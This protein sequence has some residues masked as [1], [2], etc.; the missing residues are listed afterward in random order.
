MLPF[1]AS[2][3]AKLYSRLRQLILNYSTSNPAG[4]GR[5]KLLQ[6]GFSRTCLAKALATPELLRPPSGPFHPLSTYV[7]AVT[8]TFQGT[9]IPDSQARVQSLLGRV[10]DFCASA[11]GLVSTSQLSSLD[12]L[13]AVSGV[14]V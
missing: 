13:S 14:T 4:G 8:W 6:R 7:R 10:Y 9:L 2:G 3:F 5:R 12:A 1:S 11:T